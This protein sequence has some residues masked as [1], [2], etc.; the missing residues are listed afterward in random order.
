MMLVSS[1]AMAFTVTVGPLESC[2]PIA[3][4]FVCVCGAALFVKF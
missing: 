4:V 2:D 1:G 3:L